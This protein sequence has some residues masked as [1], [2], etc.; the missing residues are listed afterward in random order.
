MSIHRFLNSQPEVKYDKE[1]VAQGGAEGGP[2]SGLKVVEMSPVEMGLII[3]G[4]YGVEAA[5]D[6]NFFTDRVAVDALLNISGRF[7]QAA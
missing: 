6:D 3:E 4:L 1:I 5:N 7:A 2:D